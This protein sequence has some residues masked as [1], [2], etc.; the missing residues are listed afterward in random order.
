MRCML[1]GFDGVVHPA[2]VGTN[3]YFEHIDLLAVWLRQHDDAQV[4]I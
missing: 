1:L 2:G 4:V 3:R